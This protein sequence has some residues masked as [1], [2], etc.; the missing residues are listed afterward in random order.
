MLE[1]GCGRVHVRTM[2]LSESGNNGENNRQQNPLGGCPLQCALVFTE[3]QSR[4]PANPQPWIRLRWLD[5]W[6]R[7]YGD[8]SVSSALGIKEVEIN[9]SGSALVSEAAS[10]LVSCLSRCNG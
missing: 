2:Q 9:M 1:T 6:H 4:E 10:E 3:G 8:V 5:P 7:G